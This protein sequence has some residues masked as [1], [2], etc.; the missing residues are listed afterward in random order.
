MEPGKDY[1]FKGKKVK[2]YP[3][4]QKGVRQPIFTDDPRDPRLR[5]YQDSLRLYNNYLKDVKWAADYYRT[6]TQDILK[7]YKNQRRPVGSEAYKKLYEEIKK[8]W[9]KFQPNI[10]HP[11]I[12][13]TAIYDFAEYPL[14]GSREYKKPV[15]PVK[16]KKPEPKPVEQPKVVEKA[17]SKSPD[18][19]TIMMNRGKK[20]ELL[21]DDFGNYEW[22]NTDDDAGDLKPIRRATPEEIARSKKQRNGGVSINRADEYPL[23]KLDNLLNFTNYNKPKA[24][25]GWLEKYK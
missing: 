12:K 4:A 9:T 10:L 3:V 15:Q 11:T 17:V 7:S 16:Y 22:F 19:V 8:N 20:V 13:P 14:T 23:E 1:K 2:E 18:P 6:N 21:V 5:N 24:K 25:N